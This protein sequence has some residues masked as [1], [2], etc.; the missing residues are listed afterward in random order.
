MILHYCHGLK[1]KYLRSVG[2]KE[3]IMGERVTG[4]DGS[5]AFLK[6][7]KMYLST[8]VTYLWKKN[9]SDH[10]IDLYL[11]KSDQMSVLKWRP[12]IN[13][14]IKKY[15]NCKIYYLHLNVQIIEL[16]KNSNLGVGTR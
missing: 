9:I 4:K 15:E 8:K 6:M 13:I 3:R 16:A 7:P 2:K 14:N 1:N 11:L 10:N 5:R 12:K